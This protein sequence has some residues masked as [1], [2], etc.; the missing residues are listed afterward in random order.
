MYGIRV[1]G[2]PLHPPDVLDQLRSRVPKSVDQTLKLVDAFEAT[3]G[4]FDFTPSHVEDRQGGAYYLQ[5]VDAQGKR[6]YEQHV[7]ANS[8]KVDRSDTS[9]VTRIEFLEETLSADLMREVLAAVE[10]GRIHVFTSACEHFNVGGSAG[11]NKIESW[12]F[13]DGG[14][15]GYADFYERLVASCDLPVVTLCHGATRG[16]GMLFPAIADI[17]LATSEATFGYPEIR[18][19]VLPGIVSVPSLRRLTQQQCRR[20]MLTGEAFDAQA[21]V[22]NGFVD[23]VMGSRA[24]DAVHDLDQVLGRLCVIPVEVLRARKKVH[25]SGGD[26]NLAIIE[27]GL[28]L[29]DVQHN[30]G[31]EGSAQGDEGTVKL[32]WPKKG[33]VLLELNDPSNGNAMTLTMAQSLAAH[34]R[35]LKKK[36]AGDLNVVVLRAAG[37]H[38]CAS[39]GPQSWMAGPADLQISFE[40]TVAAHYQVVSACCTMLQELPVPVLAVLHGQVRGAGLALALSASWRVCAEGTSFEFEDEGD[41]LGLGRTIG[42]VVGDANVSTLRSEKFSNLQLDSAQAQN[43]NLVSSV[44]DTVASAFDS[45]VALADTI[46]ASPAGGVRNTTAL[47]KSPVRT[48]AETAKA[49][50]T[51]VSS[52]WADVQ[53]GLETEVARP[54][55]SISVKGGTAHLSL[56]SALT[57]LD[58]L[59][60]LSAIDKQSA[61]SVVVTVS[62]DVVLDCAGPG[63]PKLRQ[64]FQHTEQR[65]AIIIACHGAAHGSAGL[66]L[67]LLADWA[68]IT[69]EVDFDMTNLPLF[70]HSCMA[71]RFG[72]QGC[73]RMC[74]TESMSAAEAAE[75]GLVSSVVSSMDDLGGKVQ[76]LAGH[77]GWWGNCS[78]SQALVR[79]AE[80]SA[81]Q[82]D[83]SSLSEPIQW[84]DGNVAHIKLT[85]AVDLRRHLTALAASGVNGIIIEDCGLSSRHDDNFLADVRELYATTAVQHQ[86]RGL[87][88]PVCV[89]LVG[90]ASALATVVALAADYRLGY[91]NVCFDFTLPEV[92]TLVFDVADSMPAALGPAVAEKLR[93]E[94]PVVDAAEASRMGLLTGTCM[95]RDTAM[96]TASASCTQPLRSNKAV[97]PR[98]L[99]IGLPWQLLIVMFHCN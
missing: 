12:A 6:T 57:S 36:P 39:E 92:A 86:L 84:L 4:R 13:V 25:E 81:S 27:T 19:G 64:W 29:L 10:P 61:Q 40:A 48:H 74:L 22:R 63:L 94:Q 52:W 31:A 20:W 5:R 1:Q 21:A 85:T 33:V 87:R 71:A 54:D 89:V 15:R 60:R 55:T 96:E 43:V 59:Q 58:L 16:G 67:A 78:W 28:P 99:G 37:D 45:A 26:L 24:E 38:F 8:V 91:D 9:I 65:P 46:A 93:V 69:K 90:T 77:F 2:V 30:V 73:A 14:T 18:R 95:N 44:H 3:Y 79:H 17:S 34:I 11:G 32:S 82:H 47:M 56:P 70:V 35:E 83:N 7:K 88:L 23:M 62:P 76:G 97:L 42:Q 68:I 75:I 98:C 66:L 49:C 51:Y 41:L 53:D 80:D 50:V 72:V